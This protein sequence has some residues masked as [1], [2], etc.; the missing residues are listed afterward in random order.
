MTMMQGQDLL[1][2]DVART[3]QYKSC[4]ELL[5]SDDDQTASTS[6]TT[7]QQIA[8]KDEAP[9]CEEDSS[10]NQENTANETSSEADSSKRQEDES[11]DGEDQ[12]NEYAGSTT[13][14]GA[15][16]VRTGDSATNIGDS[17]EQPETDRKSR[18]DG[19]AGKKAPEGGEKRRRSKSQPTSPSRSP[20]DSGRRDVSAPSRA[21]KDDQAKSDDH[22]KHRRRNQAAESS[23]KS[24]RNKENEQKSTSTTQNSRSKDD[25]RVGHPTSIQQQVRIFE[26]RRLASRELEKTRFYQMQLGRTGGPASRSTNKQL[27]RLLKEDFNEKAHRGYRIN[28]GTAKDLHSLETHL[29]GTMKLSP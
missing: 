19:A 22:R 9:A 5:Q 24:R 1:P 10:S 28:S 6:D 29:Q 21:T 12:S 25:R 26:M 17:E 8:M 14:D 20:H 2:I 16:G 4:V 13:E 3:K 11:N 27:T 15:E 7:K 18:R 23:P